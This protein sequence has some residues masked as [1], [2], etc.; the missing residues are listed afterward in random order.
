MCSIK[1]FLFPCH[2]CYCA[3]EV[4]TKTFNGSK[5]V[6]VPSDS[7]F[8]KALLFELE[9]TDDHIFM[10]HD[11]CTRINHS[12]VCS[13]HTKGEDL[14]PV[15]AFQKSGLIYACLPLF[16]ETLEPQPPLLT[17][18]GLSQGLLLLGIVGYISSNWKNEADVK[19]GQLQNLLTKTCLLGTPLN[20][21]I[22]SLNSSFEDI[23]E[24]LTEKN[25]PAWRS[26]YKGK[27]QVNICIT[28]KVECMQYD[29]RDVVQVYGTVN[30]NC[31]IEG[32]APNITL[33]LNLPTNGPPLQDTVVHH[34]VTSI[35]GAMLMSSSAE[36]L[37]D[38]VCNAYKFPFILP[39]DSF[40]LCYY[41]SQAPVP[42]IL[43]FYQLAEESQ[44]K[45]PVNLKLHE[46]IKIFEYCKAH[47][48]FFNRCPI[49][50]LKYKVCYNQLDLSQEKSLLVWVIG[51]KFPKSLEVSLTVTVFFGTAGKEHPTDSICTGNSAYLKLYFRIPDFTLTGCYVDQHP[52]QI[53]VPGKPKTSASWERLSSRYYI[54]NSRALA[55]KFF[56][57]IDLINFLVN[58]FLHLNK[59]DS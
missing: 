26:K 30:C 45:I 2:R 21:N 29:T 50:L 11:T 20:T 19:V 57:T 39:S 41:T 33:S 1:M 27:P 15:L 10:K 7:A 17:A 52:V 36:P 18:S 59:A 47:I 5:H 23:Q 13:I 32:S 38:S 16:E 31:D 34:F 12:S 42:P 53:F 4:S 56:C 35:D 22:H 24:I 48:L 25:Q 28:E 58:D 8:L 51:Q 49:A 40:G 43:G 55:P 6:P 44:L 14:C 37:D 3:V 46:S 54:W 9:L